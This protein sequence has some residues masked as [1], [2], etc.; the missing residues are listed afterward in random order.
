[1]NSALHNRDCPPL[2]SDGR[3]ATDYRPSCYVHELIIQQ[4]GLRNS[5]QNRMFLQQNAREL[6]RLNTQYFAEKNNC[7][8]CTFYHV[9]PNG[10]DQFWAEYKGRMERLH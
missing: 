7:N 1:M 2:M 3:F 6:M 9:D 8:S 5:H 10:Q 4:N